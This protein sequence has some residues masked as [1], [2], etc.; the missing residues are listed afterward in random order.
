[1]TT[2]RESADTQRIV[3]GVDGSEPSK[4]ALRWAAR[5]APAINGY[6]EAVIA[7]EFPAT[8]GW[9]VVVDK[10]WLP[11]VDA[12]RVLEDTLAEVFGSERPA[13]L[14]TSV[15]A[16]GASY[17]LLGASA[18]A[19]LL[20]VGSRGHGG[21]DGLLLGSVSSA[22]A[23][24]AKCPVLVVHGEPVEAS[25][26]LQRLLSAAQGGG[27][28]ESV[29]RSVLHTILTG[30]VDQLTEEGRRTLVGTLPAD[31]QVLTK[32]S[33][34]SKI[35]G[36]LFDSDLETLVA[37]CQKRAGCSRE[38]AHEIVVT[39]LQTLHE[40]LPENTRD[41]QAEL[42]TDLTAVWTASPVASRPHTSSS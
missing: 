28:R 11:D 6:I 26:V 24:H 4:A 21:F 39:V 25:A 38:T 29:A 32:S 16:G 31:V 20:V 35:K 8:Y 14:T 13:S 19:A 42:P 41:I 40:V 23:E 1:M 10:G 3:V 27:C 15:R 36:E 7:W 30:F 2:D 5:L 33:A 17:E 22:C 9:T 37:A 18:D 12:G 34:L